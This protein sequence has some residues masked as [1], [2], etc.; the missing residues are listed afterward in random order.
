[1]VLDCHCHIVPPE[2]AKDPAS[3]AERDPH[4]AMLC[5]TKNARFLTGYDLAR[6]MA[7]DGVDRAVAFGFAFKDP[8]VARLQNDHALET[9]LMNPGRVIAMAVV[10]PE[11]PGAVAEV[12]RCLSRGASGLGEVFPAGH[13]FDLCG[14]GMKRVAGLCKEAGVPVFIHV[15]ELVGH[16]YPGKGDAG[17]LA[18][19]R[20][21]V[22]NP[23]LTTIFAHFAGGLPLYAAMPEVKALEHVYYDNA[24]QPFLYKPNVYQ[25]LKALGVLDKILLGSDYPLLHCRR[26][27]RELAESGLSPDE[28]AMVLGNNADR[29]FGSFFRRSPEGNSASAKNTVY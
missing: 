14:P 17:P 20:F 11:S 10:D 19:Y 24:A 25:A 15:N 16:E 13:G 21:A 4:F 7:A 22:D 18:A 1:M 28:Q 27:I 5:R 26:Y 8:G 12:E 23:G 3:F 2:M 29:V 6:D 9:A